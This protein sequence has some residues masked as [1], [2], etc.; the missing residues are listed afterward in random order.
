MVPLADLEQQPSM[1][2]T[3]LV[4]GA[5]ANGFPRAKRD[6][7]SEYAFD[8]RRKSPLCR[9]IAARVCLAGVEGISG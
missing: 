8:Q 1:S 2:L 5:F 6:G 3:P 7:V 4:E 9:F